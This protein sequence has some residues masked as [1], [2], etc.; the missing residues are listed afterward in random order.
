MTKFILRNTQY[1]NIWT[2]WM[3]LW[4]NVFH[5]KED[6]RIIWLKIRMNKIYHSILMT[7]LINPRREK[8]EREK[9]RE[10]VCKRER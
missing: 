3:L 7:M 5:A 10:G 8:K 9:E 1:L 2:S 6:R 4:A